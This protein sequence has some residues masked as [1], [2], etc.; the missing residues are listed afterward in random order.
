MTSGLGH[1]GSPDQT[2]AQSPS[3]AKACDDVPQIQTDLTD[4]SKSIDGPIDST[5]TTKSVIDTKSS[6]QTGLLHLSLPQINHTK[7]MD[8]VSTSDQVAKVNDKII[9]LPRPQF[10]TEKTTEYKNDQS[11]FSSLIKY[12]LLS[13]NLE[14]IHCPAFDQPIRSSASSPLVFSSRTEHKLSPNLAKQ[15]LPRK[16][17]RNIPGPNISE[18]LTVTSMADKENAH[19]V[20][21]KTSASFG[22]L[23]LGNVLQ[24]GNV[25]RPAISNLKTKH[26]TVNVSDLYNACDSINESGNIHASASTSCTNSITDSES[27]FGTS[28]DVN[29]YK[30]S[31]LRNNR[32]EALASL[33]PPIGINSS[34]RPTDKNYQNYLNR[35]EKQ[36]V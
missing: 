10:N 1:I 17:N 14:R 3:S 36:T 4:T 11:L 31:G 6:M 30:P 13:P 27:N 15:N 9:K 29:C 5:K 2:H 8:V 24:S 12:D 25:N 21:W 7:S 18:S 28:C 20:K 32:N 33:R 26:L 34:R 19:D 35:Q 22:S 23:I 16:R